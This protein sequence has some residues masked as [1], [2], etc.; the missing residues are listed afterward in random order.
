MTH[1][2][3]GRVCGM[4]SQEKWDKTKWLIFEM[5]EMVAQDHFPLARLL[6]IW[7]FLLYVVCT[8]PW[9]NPYMKGLHL[10]IDSWHPFRGLDGFK[11]RGKELENALAWGSDRDMPCRRAEDELEEGGP[12]VLLMALCGSGDKEPPVEVRPVPRF[13]DDLAYLAQLTEAD[14]PPRQLYRA[15]HAA[16]LFVIGDARG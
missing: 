11:L 2:D 5:R 10:T 9:I 15:R 7:G 13:I 3:R 4:V 12:H 16:G 1:T 6:Q 8:Y 14:T